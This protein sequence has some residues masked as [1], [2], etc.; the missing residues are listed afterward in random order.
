MAQTPL[1]GDLI[2]RAFASRSG[3][4]DE[5]LPDR[6][7]VSPSLDPQS[8]AEFLAFDI[9]FEVEPV[10]GFAFPAGVDRG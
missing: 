1:P 4:L 7:R 6:E 8:V 2:A 5:P 9:P 3:A 10:T